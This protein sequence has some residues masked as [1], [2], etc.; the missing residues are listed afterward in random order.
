MDFIERLNVVS[1][2]NEPPT[3]NELRLLFPP[4]R[5]QFRR[6]WPLPHYGVMCAVMA[7]SGFCMQEVR[8]LTPKSLVI[9]KQGIMVVRAVKSSSVPVVG[10]SRLIIKQSTSGSTEHSTL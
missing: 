3:M 5:N 4:D 8:A 6:V 10:I 1:E 7:S 2:T 9:E